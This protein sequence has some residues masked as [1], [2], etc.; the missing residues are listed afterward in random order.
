[1]YHEEAYCLIFK[2]LGIFQL[3]SVIDINLNSLVVWEYI[4]H[5]F[6]VL[7]FA[8]VSFMAQNVIYFSS[9]WAWRDRVFY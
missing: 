7:N 2:Y 6:Y 8:Q 9:L 1:M 5:Y 3:S 4:W